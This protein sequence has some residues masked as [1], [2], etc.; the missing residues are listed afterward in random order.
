MLCLQEGMS[1]RQDAGKGWLLQEMRN[2][3]V[4]PFAAIYVEPSAV[5]PVSSIQPKSF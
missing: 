2:L 3:E 5:T 1:G 4:D